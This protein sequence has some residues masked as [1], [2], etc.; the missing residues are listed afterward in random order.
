MNKTMNNNVIGLHHVTAIASD[1]KRN[2]DFYT[3]VLGLRFVK[4]TVNFDDPNT[5]HLYYGNYPAEPGTIL[6]FFPWPN[7]MSGRR[8][9]GQATETGFSVPEGSLDFWVKR[10]DAHGITYNKPATKFGEEYLTVLDPDGMKLE[11][12]VSA[13]PDARQQH[14]T[15]E[16]DTSKAIR[17]FQ[18]VTI[19]QADIKGTADVLTD[20]LDYELA[21][22]QVNRY[23][24]VNKNAPTASGI[25]LVEAP[26]E[27]RGH[28]AGGSVHH[29]A[30]RVKD[31]ATEMALRA[32]IEAKG[33]NITPQIDRNYFHSLYFR[34][35]GGVLFEI[36]TDNPGFMVDEPL[37][38][39]GES[40]KLPA[41]Y[42]SRRAAIEA[43]LPQM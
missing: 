43:V 13:K 15:S 18:N 34:E 11:L 32:K 22:Q 42:E 2:Y 16:I 41:M 24:F 10:L 5:Y 30:F 23:R 29:V 19:T 40:L 4:K 1:A 36:A 14:I 17:G 39:L 33:F 12:T 35:P 9:T 7:I 37:E 25:D 26:G 38:H 28:V 20:L 6:T 3:K 21:E 8:G 27:R 31:D